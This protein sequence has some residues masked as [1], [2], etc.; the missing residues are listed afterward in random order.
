MVAAG[1]RRYRAAMRPQ[2]RRRIGSAALP[3]PADAL[4]AAA[5]ALYGLGHVWLGWIPDEGHAGGPRGLNTVVVLL[6]TLPLAWRR[7]AP[8]AVLSVIV[9]AFSLP[10]ILTGAM[11]S[12]FA[13]LMPAL[14]AGYSV[15]RFEPRRRVGIGIAVAVLGMGALIATTPEFRRP[16]ELLFEAILWTAAWLLG[17]TVRRGEHRARELGRRAQRLEREREAQAR[18]AVID[19][20]ARIARELHDVVAHGVSLIVVQAGGARL[21]LDD[22]E[23][24][25]RVRTHLRAIEDSGR[26]ALDEMRRLLA[27]LRDDGVVTLEPLPGIDRLDALVESAREA[28]VRVEMRVEGVP[29]T[30]PAG[31]DLTAYRI[32]QEALTNVIRHAGPASAEVTVR[33]GADALELEVLDDGRGTAQA[34]GGGHGLVGMHERTAL[35]G[36]EL[37]VGDRPEG[38]YAVRVR[39]P[40]SR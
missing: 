2:R 20:R 26:Q 29:E 31:V 37:D 10:Q 11:A 30:L 24:T 7:I 6:T 8:L 18:A 14:V 28:D 40:L 34:N 3:A 9:A 36:G 16:E 5:F 38:G 33:Y 1:T 12:F 15:A 13:G 25:D 21:L 35:Y 39:L 22:P 17:S 27:M 32:V 19:E 4:L 23:G